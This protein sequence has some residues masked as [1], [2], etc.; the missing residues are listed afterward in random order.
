MFRP[1]AAVLGLATMIAVTA[2][3]G[4]GAGTGKVN[5]GAISIVDVAPLYLGE[6]KG[7]FGKRKIDLTITPTTG[8]AAAVPG[9]VSGQFTFAF[10]NVTSVLVAR[11]RGLD[12]KVV[13]NG[14]NSTGRPGADFGAVMVR[15]DSPI[16]SA[17]DLAGRT[18]SVNNLRNIG[19]TTIRQVVRKAGGDPTKIKFV[20]LPF[21]DAPAALQGG[22]VDAAWVVEPFVTQAKSQGARAVAWNFAEAIPDLTIAV[23]FASGEVVSEQPD[24]V[25]RFTAAINESLAYAQAHPGEAREVLKTY[26][27]IPPDAISKITMPSWPTAVNRRS[28]QATADLALGDGLLKKKADVGALFP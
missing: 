7:F 12:L 11:D 3:C 16:T 14:V 27:K 24:L 9:V 21:P 25:K 10:G 26:T 8:G 22:R 18:V 28:V 13:A 6:Q 20:E 2:G 23:Y 4:G 5:V 17:K 19:D 1:L 15:A